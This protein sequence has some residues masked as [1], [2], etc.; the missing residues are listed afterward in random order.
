M[1]CADWEIHAYALADLAWACRDRGEMTECCTH[2][3]M[4]QACTCDASG[5]I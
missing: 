5:K 3:G 1:I 2:T 4:L